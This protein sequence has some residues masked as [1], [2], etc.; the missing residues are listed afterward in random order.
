MSLLDKILAQKRKNDNPPLPGEKTVK[1]W[2]KESKLPLKEARRRLDELVESGHAKKV[3]RRIT[4]A[5]GLRHADH[6]YESKP[7]K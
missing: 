2:A 3:Q 1:E 7:A 6:Y 4:W 5:G